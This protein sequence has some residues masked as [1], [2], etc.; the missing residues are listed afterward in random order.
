MKQKRML[1]ND[2]ETV[3]KLTYLDDKES[4]FE[5]C[6]AAV[7]AGQDMHGISLWNVVSYCMERGFLS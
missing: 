6:E 1:C 4:A 3:R 5:I 2:M 7:N